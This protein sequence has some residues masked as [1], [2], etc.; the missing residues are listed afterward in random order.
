MAKPAIVFVC[1]DC[2][3]ETLKWQG[4]CP[5]CSHWNTL[6]QRT[7]ARRAAGPGAAAA[8]APSALTILSTDDVTRLLTGMDELD[9]VFGGGI[10][11]GSVTLLGGEPGIGKSTLLLQL[12]NHAAQSSPTLYLSAEE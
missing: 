5:Q 10:I 9:R 12:A 3:A 6:E 4:Q 11:P 7:V 8:A 2:G 1:A